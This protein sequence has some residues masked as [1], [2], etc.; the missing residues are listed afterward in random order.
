MIRA[1][2]SL[3][4]TLLL[5][6][7]AQAE[8]PCRVQGGDSIAVSGFVRDQSGSPVPGATVVAA[9]NSFSVSTQSNG[10]GHYELPLPKGVL[11][12]KA[13]VIGFETSEQTV[14]VGDKRA[15]NSLDITMTVAAVKTQV[16]VI[17]NADSILTNSAVG[18]K[19]STPLIDIPQMV[20]IVNRQFLSDLQPASAQ[21]ALRYSSGYGDWAAGSG[22]FDYFFFRGFEATD[23]TRVDGLRGV[24][25]PLTGFDG[26]LYDHLEILK[27]P[28]S[29]LYGRTG[30]SGFVS[31]VSKAPGSTFRGDLTAGFG[32]Y[33]RA[34]GILN[35]TGSPWRKVALGAVALYRRNATAITPSSPS[36]ANQRYA[37]APTAG[38]SFT[39]ATRITF[40]GDFSYD[41]TNPVGGGSGLPFIGTIQPNP[42][43]RVPVRRDLGEPEWARSKV[44]YGSLTYQFSHIFSPNWI[45]R[46]NGGYRYRY[47][48]FLSVS[49]L[50]LQSNLRRMNRTAFYDPGR[51]NQVAEIDTS[52]EGHREFFGARHTV[53]L[54]FDYLYQ[55]DY[56]PRYQGTIASID[57]FNPVYGA[58]PVFPATLS[59]RYVQSQPSS[60][61]YLQDQA[62]WFGRLSLVLGARYDWANI[63]YTNLL[64]KAYT[65]TNNRA[66]TPRVG[67][68]YKLKP[69]MALYSSWSKSFLPQ[70]GTDVRGRLFNPQR[71]EQYEAGMKANGWGDRFAITAA[72]FH[73][74]R[75]NVLTSDLRNPGFSLE[76]GNQRSQGFETDFSVRPTR[77]W[78]F[79]GSYSLIDAEVISDNTIP[80]GTAPINTARNQGSFWTTYRFS[81]VRRLSPLNA[82]LGMRAVGA[83]NGDP[84]GLTYARIPAY[85]VFDAMASWDLERWRIAVNLRNLTNRYYVSNSYAP[86]VYM[87][88]PITATATVSFR[89]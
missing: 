74:K 11:T 53:L 34:D 80:R 54:G 31:A 57:V 25:R 73:L 67:L 71:G 79:L 86:T 24:G 4:A 52:I 44:P 83:R 81:K 46:Q 63:N 42:Y 69:Q 1:A 5:V 12:I 64:N 26:A 47:W 9:C 59:R 21:Q 82:G 49:T 61:V 87:G 22:G 15:A 89:F 32:T 85:V 33:G 51:T 29:V 37:F 13:V 55:R 3:F 45:L 18:T 10:N 28:A 2:A 76:T 8:P 62:M 88:E 78:S 36:P 84:S 16:A 48:D 72:L 20:Q 70:S 68:V 38:I 19:T 30:A 77:Q 7:L 23:D 75:T 35:I 6:V 17:E 58:Q 66:A 50:S 40:F 39:D 14:T 56:F 60:G 65:G 41:D 27:G 43:G